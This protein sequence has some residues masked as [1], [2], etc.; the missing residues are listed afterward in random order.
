MGGE[1]ELGLVDPTL[2]PLFVDID[3]PH[4]KWILSWFETSKFVKSLD[5]SGKEHSTK[6]HGQPPSKEFLA[7]YNWLVFEFMDG[8]AKQW[9][10]VIKQST[11]HRKLLMP[12]KK[13]AYAN[14]LVTN[15]VLMADSID[16]NES[17]MTKKKQQ[18]HSGSS[19]LCL[20]VNSELG[21]RSQVSWQKWCH[22]P[23]TEKVFWLLSSYKVSTFLNMLWV[24]LHCFPQTQLHHHPIIPASLALSVTS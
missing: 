18:Q 4:Q 15:A 21:N 2:T 19:S 16:S 12:E 6:K 8:S 17:S 13:K 11:I 24:L 3:R 10:S 14:N 7:T 20:D 1:R 23:F 9:P 5:A 22:F